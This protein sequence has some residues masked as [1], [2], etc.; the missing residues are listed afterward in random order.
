MKAM[1]NTLINSIMTKSV[2]YICMFL[3]LLGTSA[4]AWG[5]DLR[6]NFTSNPGSWPTSSNA[7]SYTYT[8]NGT[9]YTFA[10]SANVYCNTGYLMVKENATLGLPAISGKKLTKI[11][12]RNSSG[13][14]TSTSVSVTD[15]SSTV[16]G[17]TAQTFSTRS[18]NYT[19]TLTGTSANTVYYLNIASANCQIVALTLTYENTAS[20]TVSFSALN[21]TPASSSASEGS[22][23]AGVTLPTVTINSDVTDAGWK[24][25][26]WAKSSVGTATT[27]TPAIVGKA[28]DTYYPE[29]TE[30]LYA[31]YAK[32]EFTKV[33]ST[34]DITS[35]AKYLILG[36]DYNEA[37][38]NVWQM[39]TDYYFNGYYWMG[40][41]LLG[42]GDSRI[43]DSYHAADAY[44]GSYLITGTAA[45][46]V[47]KDESN[48]NFIDVYETNWLTAS[49]SR[50]N[51]ITFGSGGHCT[52]KNNSGSRYL[53]VFTTGEFGDNS[54]AWDGMMLYKET[55][56]SKYCSEPST[57]K[58]VASPIAGGT[59]VFDDN[60]SDEMDFVTTDE[61][62]G[63]ITATPNSGYEFLYWESSDEDKVTVNDNED[64]TTEIY[65]IETAT[66]TAYFYQNHSLTYTLTGVDGDPS[67]PTTITQNEM[68]G[69]VSGFDIKAHYKEMTLVSVTMGGSPL[70]EGAEADYEWAEDGGTA[71]LTIHH[72]NID[73]DIVIT[74]SATPMEYTKYAFSCSELTLTPH[75]VTASTPIFITSTASTTVRSQDYIEISGNGLTPSTELTFPGLPAKFAIKNAD[76]T[77]IST[78]GS[79]EVSANAYIFYTPGA[80]DTG[81]GLDELSGI[82]V[83]VSGA[84]PKQVNLSQSI[85]GRHLPADFVIAGKK[86]NKWYAL[87]ADFSDESTPAPVEIAVDDINNPSIA[88]TASTNIYNLYGQNSGASGFLYND[89]D[90]DGNPDGE[91]I[92]LGMKNNSNKPL[93]AFASP[94]NSLKGDGTA[95]VTNNINKQYWWT[96]KQVNTT[97]NISNAQDA[98]Y[99]INSSNNSGTLSIKNSPFA[100]GTYASGVEE[101]RLIPASEGGVVFA[102]ASV[103][104]WGK[105]SAIIEADAGAVFAYSVIGKLPDDIESSKITLTQ[106]GTSVKGTG[107]RYN[108]TVNFGE[109][110]D[111]SANEGKML[112]LEWYDILDN[113]KA[114]SNVMVPRIVATNT[115]INSAN[116]STKSVW[117]TEV[118]VLPGNT[119]F[120][121]A[122]GY[123]PNKNVTINELHIYPNATVQVLKDTL[124]AKNLILRNGWNRLTAETEYDVARLYIQSGS[125]NGTLKATNAYLD[126]YID[127]DQ[128]YPIA[129]P[130]NV[131]TSSISYRNTSGAASAGLTIRHYDGERH[132]KGGKDGDGNTNWQQYTWGDDMPEN[133]VPGIGYAITA[134]RP[135]GKAFSIVR[136]PLTIPST[137]W[138]TLGE[139]GEVSSVHKDQVSVT[140]WVRDEGETP[141]HAKGWNFIANPYMSIYE[142]A[143]THSE[144]E[145]YD[146]EYV[147]IPDVNFKEFEQVATETAKLKP[148]GGVLIQT[149]ETGTLTFGT[150]NRKA[151][152]PSYLTETP[153][154]SKQKAYILL[155]GNEAVDQMG[156]IISDNYTAEYEVNADLEKLLSDGN[157]LRTYMIY[158]N[159]NMAYVAI[160]EVLA[161]EWIPVSVRIPAT[162]EYT[163]SIHEASKVSELE[164]VYLIDYANGGI[165]TNLI[166][167]NYTFVAEA[168]TIEGRFAI[169]AKVG[170]HKV[171]TDIDIVNGGG[172][173]KSDAPFKFLYDDKA[174]I[175]HRGVI[176][177]AMGKRVREINR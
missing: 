30:T 24:L 34:G 147:N 13:C 141:D 40:G 164:G 70:T 168:G 90:D 50:K 165:V 83:C 131:A 105:N 138:T 133:L 46:Y 162:G 174:Y 59:V 27:T 170:Q 87:P 5:V 94:K 36:D 60:N 150:A 93:F 79:G 7:G 98:K 171:P 151:S 62:S 42:N 63:D 110:V 101:L 49:S 69:F 108:Y 6:F 32:G 1:N 115:T 82:T 9:S 124:I 146:I 11:V 114:I 16:T 153:K 76:G 157:T 167:E 48:T 156:L 57:V 175:Y 72:D 127:Y 55:K 2:K 18:T 92:K 33:T 66:L 56:T 17:G 45:N 132:A 111:F 99:I 103:V 53:D 44:P 67:N 23:N 159:L 134:R 145:D 28:G 148:G 74:V 104:A 173:L 15:G 97:I 65:A 112:T 130:W 155:S 113:L 116:Y 41:H 43:K 140:A 64:P 10:L 61:Y 25:Y 119:L 122:S 100:W 39:G 37:R 22:A 102:G 139:Q 144:G 52:I 142:G 89:G 51:T 4:Y 161:Q 123:T 143:I 126:W 29:K 31:V 117:A 81:D 84:K 137:A 176:Y 135:A 75:L 58:L 71:M 172:D 35:G 12:V 163:F 8:L 47:I 96:L 121:D 177:D 152:A 78:N 149:K 73:G 158:N 3:L 19:Y 160:N 88:Y 129:V 80:G 38:K 128:Y 26:G 91:K 107:T 166:E 54:T 118:H 86:D 109:G 14:S 20:Y 95:T 68:N 154:V 125:G 85:I 77:A 21:G 120:I 136:M 106:T 169:N